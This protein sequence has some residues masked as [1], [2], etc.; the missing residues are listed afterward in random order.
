M[1]DNHLK[2]KDFFDVAQFPQANFESIKIKS[3]TDGSFLILGKLSMHGIA[4]DVELKAKPLIASTDQNGQKHL[5]TEATTD[6][7]RKDFKVGGLAAVTV[8]NLVT[9]YMLMDLIK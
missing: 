4:Q 2:S 3:Q 9:V 7:K 6:L 1:R 5:K 8:S